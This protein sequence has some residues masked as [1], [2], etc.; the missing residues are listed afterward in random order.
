M[1]SEE[2]LR[3]Y[4]D[5]LLQATVKNKTILENKKLLRNIQQD[6]PKKSTNGILTSKLDGAE[7]K[8]IN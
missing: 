8:F 7:T 1:R 3:E 6:W 2:D 4:A 5:I